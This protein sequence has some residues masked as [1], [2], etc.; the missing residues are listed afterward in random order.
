MLIEK[1]IIRAGYPN[2]LNYWNRYKFLI[3]KG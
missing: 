2:L 3:L 1:E